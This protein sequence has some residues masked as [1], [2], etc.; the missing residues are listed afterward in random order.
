MRGIW[1][2]HADIITVRD[3]QSIAVRTTT[4]AEASTFFVSDNSNEDNAFW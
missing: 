4:T 3:E 1:N 2:H